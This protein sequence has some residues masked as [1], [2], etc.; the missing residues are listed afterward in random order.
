Q[1]CGAVTRD[2]NG[3]WNPDGA[4][5]GIF[6][7]A[8]AGFARRVADHSA[9]YAEH[10]NDAIRFITATIET[11]EAFRPELH[12]V[13]GEAHAFFV[14]PLRYKDLRCN[15]GG[16]SC[17]G[18][19]NGAGK[20]LPY[21]ENLSM[22]QAL[23]EVALASDGAMYRGSADATPE[24][25]RLATEEAPLLIAR[26][27]AFFVDN[28]R[29]NTL[30][31]GSPYFEW[32]YQQGQS[33]IQNIPHG[34]FEL[35]CLAVLQ[36]KQSRLDA[37]LARAG[38]ADRLP[39]SPALFVGFANTFLRKIWRHDVLSW[40]VDG[41]GNENYN[42]ECAG[43]VPLAQFDPWV[44]RRCRDTTFHNRLPDNTSPDL[45]EDNHA[46]LLRYR[47]FSAMKFLT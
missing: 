17:V 21:N 7:Y 44:W 30:S 14:L 15:N 13:E 46:A 25:L 33:S 4:T 41:S 12:L 3:T 24:R 23:A 43:W 28:L 26:N 29:R 36:D 35:G 5:S 11:Y 16:D 32:D 38:R 1:V 40:K 42:T 20:P 45:R 22:M 31:D 6:T 2:R 9:R 39:L 8:M 47:E 27:V 34:G 10:R 18:Y 19:R 37:L